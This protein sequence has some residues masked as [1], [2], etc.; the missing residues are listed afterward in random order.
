MPLAPR[1]PL[2]GALGGL[3]GSWG[4]SGALL[5]SS[6]DP[7]GSPGW[8]L[9]SLE[10]PWRGPWGSLG[11]L[12]GCSGDHGEASGEPRGTLDPPP[13]IPRVPQ[14]LPRTPKC[15]PRRPRGNP[16]G[17]S[18]EPQGRFSDFRKTSYFLRKAPRGR[19]SGAWRGLGLLRGPAGL[20][21]AS[22]ESTGDPLGA[23]N[24]SDKCG[25]RKG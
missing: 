18:G 7:C 13:R 20:L 12:G 4:V 10:R 6:G 23:P 17:A 21:G 5:G 9:G 3:W 2:G 15:T 11:A 8:L 19:L 25:K 1:D 14:G 22:G 24:A 16:R